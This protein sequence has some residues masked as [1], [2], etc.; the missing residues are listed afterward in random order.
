M[1]FSA[2]FNGDCKVRYKEVVVFAI[3]KLKAGK[4]DGD[5]GL[6]SDY[7]LHACSKLFV[8]I[9]LL[10]TCLLV[11]YYYLAASQR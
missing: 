1:V 5:I 10:F 6:S 7:F 2:G 9:S 3:C 11:H 4:N 8:H